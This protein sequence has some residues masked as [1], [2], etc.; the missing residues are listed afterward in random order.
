MSRGD[1]TLRQRSGIRMIANGLRPHQHTLDALWNRG[2]LKGSYAKP[3]LNDAG[4]HFHEHGSLPD[5][6][7]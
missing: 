6:S 4:L 5:C 2:V 1:F 3:E 7:R